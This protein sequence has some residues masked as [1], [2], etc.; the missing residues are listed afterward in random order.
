M[1]ESTK[2]KAGRVFL[3]PNNLSDDRQ[4]YIAPHEAELLENCGIWLAESPKPCRRIISL[5]YKGETEAEI[6]Y[7]AKDRYT[8]QDL[9]E[10]FR[11]VEGGENLGIISDAGSPAIADPGSQWVR[12]AQQ[13]GLS[14]KPLSG[15]SS[16]ILALMASGFYAQ[17]FHF[18]G[19][20]PK[21]DKDLSNFVR[22]MGKR[23]A[24][25]GNPEIFMDTPYRAQTLFKTLISTL[26]EDL[27]VC[28]A[29][30]LQRSDESVQTKTIAQWKRA[31]PDL[32]RKEIVY[33]VGR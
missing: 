24:R 15:P 6:H 11:R 19:Y 26:P 23:V 33:I 17:E 28:L 27:S 10:I 29:I 14:V 25:S 4:V 31:L 1:T 16:F 3:V 13:L 30:N 32:K 9:L 7:P 22:E 8:P 12:M 21:Q 18:H 2:N 20:A 5:L